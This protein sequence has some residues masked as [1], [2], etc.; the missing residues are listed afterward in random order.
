MTVEELF[1]A[2]MALPDD[3]KA[4]LAERLVAYLGSHVDPEVEQAHLKTAK[5]RRGEILS[6]QVEALE[7]DVVMARARQLVGG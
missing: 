3:S 6:G 2:A 7:G 1:E 5:R 4:S